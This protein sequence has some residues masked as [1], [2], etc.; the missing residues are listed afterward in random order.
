[1]PAFP[2][3]ASRP[4]NSFF[5]EMVLTPDQVKPAADADAIA[6]CLAV[7]LHQEQEL[8]GRVDDDGAGAFLA[9]IVDQLLFVSRIERPLRGS[10]A[11][12]CGRIDCCGSIGGSGDCRTRRQAAADTSVADSLG[13]LGP[14]RRRT[15]L[16]EA[17]AHIGAFGIG[18]AHLGAGG[19]GWLA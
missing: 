3:A 19:A 1:V 17:A 5:A 12:S 13:P 6:Q 8:V 4:A 10:T 11:S 16:D 18:R 15:G 7:A 9:V 2:A 14:V